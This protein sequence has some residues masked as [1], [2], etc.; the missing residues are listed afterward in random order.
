M[1]KMITSGLAAL[2]LLVG[3]VVAPARA[4]MFAGDTLSTFGAYTPGTN[5]NINN[6]STFGPS[7]AST[8]TSGTGD[9]DRNSLTMTGTNFNADASTAFAVA[10]LSYH[11]GQ[12][13]SGT[14]ATDVAVTI[15]LQFTAP[16]GFPTQTF[17]FS[18][19]FDLTPNNYSPP[20]NPLNDDILTPEN[21][22]ASNT[23]TYDGQ[24]YTLHLLG[25]SS[26]G[27]NTITSQFMLPEDQ[28]VTSDL[29]GE[30]TTDLGPAAAPEPA[31]LVMGAMG[32][33]I[34]LGARRFRRGRRSAHP[35][36]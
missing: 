1:N 26:D 23:F 7:G 2:T 21:V 14:A 3:G 22:Y 30:I 33:L 12:T 6:S 31:T 17:D 24:T 16:S 15:A 36:R 13:E 35:A 5:T 19:N 32:G 34:L 4:G 27:G 18:F 28:T 11:N 10:G 29:Y 9:P 25:F 20:S 8:F